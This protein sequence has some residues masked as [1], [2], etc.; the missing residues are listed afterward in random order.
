MTSTIKSILAQSMLLTEHG[1]DPNTLTPLQESTNLGGIQFDLS[2]ALLS[3]IRESFNQ[4]FSLAIALRKVNRYDLINR[5]IPLFKSP[6]D[7]ILL[8]MVSHQDL[9]NDSTH[10]YIN[11]LTQAVNQIYK[12]YYG[13]TVHNISPSHDYIPGSQEGQSRHD[14]E[15][16]KSGIFAKESDHN[17]APSVIH[18]IT[19]SREDIAS[20][21]ENNNKRIEIQDNNNNNQDISS[22]QFLKET[23]RAAIA[24]TIQQEENMN[25][26]NNNIDGNDND[27]TRK[28]IQ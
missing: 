10:R 5:L 12:E 7:M 28:E 20:L 1:Y 22:T 6:L 27:N 23:M 2:S 13:S 16:F 14:D 26:V 18:L 4:A 19:Q 25:N 8:M 17:L 24:V 9:D 15:Q 11:N 21:N 3:Q